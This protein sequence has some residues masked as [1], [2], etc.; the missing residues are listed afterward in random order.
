MKLFFFPVFVLLLLW[1]CSPTLKTT[2]THGHPVI[3]NDST[4]YGII[5]T[6]IDFE[7]WYTLHFS[8]AKD[9]SNEYYRGKNQAAV[10]NWNIYFTNNRYHQAIDDYIYYDN[11]IDYGI[12][13]NRKLYWY[14]NF[15][16]DKYRIRLFN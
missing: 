9:H 6:D 16:Q 4:E 11:S 10:S 14:F 1:S 3:K 12:E 8:P 15:V 5:I 13:V 7:N 2:S